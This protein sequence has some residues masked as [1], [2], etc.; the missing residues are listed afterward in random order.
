MKRMGTGK[1][2]ELAPRDIEIFKLLERYR[3]LRSTYIHAFVGGASKT[4]FKERLGDLFHEAGYLDRP[5]EQWQA[6]DARYFPTI[7]ENTERAR[8]LLRENGYEDLVRWSSERSH[9][10]QFAHTLLTCEVM[11]SIEFAAL[12]DGTIR[13]IPMMEILAKAP[14]ATRTNPNP[15]AIPVYSPELSSYVVPDGLCGL[16]YQRDEKRSYRFFALEIDRATMPVVRSRQGQ[17]SFA[18]KLSAYREIISRQVYKSH[19]GLPNL[20]VLTVTANERH[21][22]EIMRAT[23][24]LAGEGAAF[25]FKALEGG[26][27]NPMRS[28]LNEAWERA[29]YPSLSISKP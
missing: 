3:Y 5:I 23:A 11:A 8:R 7:Y 13:F 29:D 15:V 12:A 20:L 10:R 16:E 18:G 4:R 26:T 24:N 22:A 1:R 28:L 21:K 6:V 27:E 2:I 14:L 17:T 25:L 9:N 19:L